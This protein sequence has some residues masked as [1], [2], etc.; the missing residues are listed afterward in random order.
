[1]KLSVTE[2]LLLSLYFELFDCPYNPNDDTKYLEF[3][4]LLS[5]H[6]MMQK[7]YFIL[8]NLNNTKDFEFDFN[9]MGPI[10][11][12]LQAILNQLDQKSD[13]IKEFYSNYYLQRNTTDSNVMIIQQDYKNLKGSIETENK[14]DTLVN[15][16]YAIKTLVSDCTF[17]EVVAYLKKNGCYYDFH[18]TQKMWEVLSKYEIEKDKEEL[19]T[20]N[21]KTLNMKKS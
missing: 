6:A 21:E 13:A 12:E 20:F 7:G 19:S 1:M 2:K 11:K 3:T 17:E 15:M 5:R 14:Q 9:W 16:I 4:S 10:S 18:T 8:Q